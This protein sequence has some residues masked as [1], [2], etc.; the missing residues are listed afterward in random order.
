MNSGPADLHLH[1]V[2]S[3]GTQTLVEMVSR[4]RA[5]GLAAVAITDHD[6]ISSELCERVTM[7]Q[8]VE[9]ITGVELKADFDGVTGELLGY[10]VDPKSERLRELLER[11]D[12]ARTSRMERMV[13]K[14]R[15]AGFEVDMTDVRRH[16]VGNLGRPHLARA[17]V[18]SGA[19][20]DTDEAF[21][22]FIGRG[23]RCYVTLEKLGFRDAVE[24]LHA[25]G[26]AVS[27]AHPC[28]MSVEDWD[29]FLDALV[30][31]GIDGMETEYPYRTPS[32]PQ[33]TISPE[34][35]AVK[36]GQRNLLTTGGSDDHGLLSSKVTLGQIRLPYE[37]VVALKKI[38]GVGM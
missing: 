13:D 4:A 37:H 23:R 6:T 9:V 26:G 11:M 21:E 5:S 22:R 33:L 29:S 2:A 36:A 16:A 3:D 32:A 14:C 7:L 25:A 18:E 28:L 15:E 17:L 27:L 1:T 10:F 24:I 19:I 31:G 34:L 20:E 35:L 12:Q 8:G 30:A 38:A